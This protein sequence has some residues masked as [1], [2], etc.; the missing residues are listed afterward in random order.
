MLLLILATGATD[1]TLGLLIFNG[2]VNGIILLPL[3][4][5]RLAVLLE[6]KGLL[7]TNGLL[8]LLALQTLCLIALMKETGLLTFNGLTSSCTCIHVH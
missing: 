3:Q 1:N 5:L 6:Q 8:R 7:V 4:T 2:L